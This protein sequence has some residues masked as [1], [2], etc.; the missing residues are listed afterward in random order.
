MGTPG[1]GPDTGGDELVAPADEAD[2]VFVVGAR[3]R[4]PRTV[5]PGPVVRAWDGRA[6]PVAWLPDSGRAAF[7][8]LEEAS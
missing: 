2:A 7:T 5:L 3:H 1:R 8:P 6:V 4:S